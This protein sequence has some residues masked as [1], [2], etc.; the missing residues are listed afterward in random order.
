[1][2]RLS[3]ILVS[4][5]VAA[6]TLSLTSTVAS[7]AGGTATTVRSTTTSPTSVAG[8]DAN[9]VLRLE[10]SNSFLVLGRNAAT[11]GSSFHVWKMK[12]DLTFDTSFGAKD[13]GADFSA[14]TASN[15]TCSTS[16]NYGCSSINSF[17]VNEAADTFAVVYSRS[18]KGAGTSSSSSINVVSVLTGKISTGAI[19]AQT[20]Y[21][22]KSGYS[23]VNLADWSAYS[24]NELSIPSCT[25]AFGATLNSTPLGNTFLNL[26]QASL[27]FDGAIVFSFDC[28]YSNI[29]NSSSGF[30][31]REFEG[32]AMA[33]LMPS[34]GTFAIDTTFGTS[35]YIKLSSPLTE[36]ANL[37]PV[38]TSDTS[39]S[40]LSSTKILFLAQ[41]EST[42][43]TTTI[44]N[45]L[46][47]QNPSSYEGCYRNG[48]STTSVATLNSFTANGKLIK[49]AT[50]PV[51]LSF[52]SFR[53]VI[54]PQ[55]RW[56]TSVSISPTG[57]GM[58]SNTPT[59]LRLLPDGS[60]DT[61]FGAN[62]MKELTGL[63]AS[64]TVNGVSVTMRYSLSGLATTA[65]GSYFVGFASTGMSTC[66]G[67]SGT[68]T[69][70]VYPYY[71]NV[72]AGLLTTYGTNGLGDEVASEI[73][74]A[75]SCGGDSSLGG[76]TYINSEGRPAFVRQVAAIG[77]QVAGL[78]YV[79]WDAADGVVGGGDGSVSAPTSTGRV[80]KKVYSTKLPK[81]TQAD[82]ALTVL[83]NKQAA[84]LDIRSTTPKICIA[85]TTTVLMVNPGR[86]IVRIIDEDTKKVLR[87]M[88]TLVKKTE[89]VEG[90]TLTTDEPIYFRQASVRLSK[91]AL[92]QVA[93]LA[94][95][96]KDA[97]RIVV[98]GHSAAL[99][100][101][102]PYSFAIS[103]N[104]A[105]AVK[106]ALVKAGVKATIEI[107]A[108]SYSQP[109]KAAK[110][111]GA[112][113]KNRRVEVYVF[114]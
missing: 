89:V 24:S 85:L 6:G 18:L 42:P 8:A 46:T 50:F 62:G 78:N 21:L 36:C 61:T 63:P 5:A 104:R 106:A 82:S 77:S 11:A 20:K 68:Y 91:N 73:S 79:L 48:P 29:N 112:Q 15:S 34:N 94:E 44:P 83:T 59:M 103:R 114:P 107:V 65:K 109:E 64:I 22:E 88:S 4:L 108:M 99:G 74:N 26:Y 95:A 110:T 10:K 25:A 72:E 71:F 38:S 39:I 30:A 27:R 97:K 56:N 37:M 105:I 87:T 3:S 75:G 49:A 28:N 92:A 35:G 53:W 60:P 32:V 66:N 80:D 67:S 45:Y 96:A 52:Y 2:R 40:S 17:L 76:V 100:D 98:I 84:D 111:E 57:G 43:R 31:A 51:G 93:E 16:N 47:G 102:S 19:I 14:P 90:T 55:G 101:V 23:A 12:E 9:R 1:M 7:A 113:A 33:A 70:K 86:C 13:L 81:T 41:T 69:S 54:D 58:P